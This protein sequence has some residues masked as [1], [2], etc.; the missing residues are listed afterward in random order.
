VSHP[1]TQRPGGRGLV[2]GFSA[3]LAVLVVVLG[4]LVVLL[5]RDG[6]GEPALTAPE[7]APAGPVP[8]ADPTS[9]RGTQ[10]F[11]ESW[12]FAEAFVQRLADRDAEAA[13]DVLCEASRV[14]V[15]PDADALQQR[16]DELV[17]GRVV[18]IAAVNAVGTAGTD[19][20]GI[21]ADLQDGSGAAYF[22]VV[23]EAED[24]RLA[25]CAIA[26]DSAAPTY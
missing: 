14:V 12:S 4:V 13:Y 3:L 10:N 7:A 22:T 21:H 5:V 18:D 26:D 16:F 9:G 19:Y 1:P 25:V 24:G 23:I 17:H 20:V 6:G 11:R 8:D 2:V 15:Y